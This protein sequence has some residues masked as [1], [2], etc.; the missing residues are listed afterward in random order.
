MPA[1]KNLVIAKYPI[2]GRLFEYSHLGEQLMP[3]GTL[4][5]G[6]AP[7][8]APL[9]W[10]HSIY[11]PLLGND[12]NEME[13]RLGHAIPGPYRRFL[14]ATNGINIFSTTL[15]LYGLRYNYKRNIEDVW[16]PFDIVTPNTIEKPGNAGDNIFIIGSYDWDGSYL[17]IDSK[18]G[19]IHLCDREDARSNYS[20]DSFYAMLESEIN[21]L[22]TRFDKEGKVLNEDESTLPFEK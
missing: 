8:I 22:I 20:W 21:R 19:K 17:Y 16:Q 11:P 2:L 14:I 9:A 18:S 15:S 13:K 1:D 3:N 12:L 5:I 6:K 10:L 7:H 4:L